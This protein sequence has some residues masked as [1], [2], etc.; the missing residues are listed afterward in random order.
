LE[1]EIVQG[2]HA[3]QP[4]GV[5]A[6]QLSKSRAAD[7]TD[8]VVEGFGD[9]QGILVGPGEEVEIME[10]GAFQIAQVIIGGAAAAQTQA[11]EQ[12]APPAEK[13]AVII[14]QGLIA[15]IGQPVQPRGQFREKMADGAEEGAR[16]GYDL[17]RWR[18]WAVT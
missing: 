6:E 9:R 5:L 14:D 12:Q 10:N 15:R 2:F 17:P 1:P 4:L 8:K 7:M 18:R 3:D 13:T 11:K 16:Q